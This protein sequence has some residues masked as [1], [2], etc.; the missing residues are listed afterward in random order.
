[1]QKIPSLF[2]RDYQDGRLVI[3]EIVPGSEW[4]TAGQAK[5]ATVKFDGTACLVK[6]GRLYKRYDRRLPKKLMQR[7]QAGLHT[8]SADEYPPAPEGWEPAQE[9]PD[10]K[11]GHWPGWLPVGDGPEDK[12]HREAW[13]NEHADRILLEGNPIFPDGP[14]LPDGTYEL[15]GPK[16]QSNPYGL[17]LHLLYRHGTSVLLDVPVDFY[18][19]RY[20]FERHP[21]LE[22][23]VWYHEDGRMVKLKRRDYG[24]PWPPQS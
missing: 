11:T 24:F 22:G 1:M 5:K 15:A 7:V 23:V 19:L 2:M 4:V 20:F 12:Y 17:D 10:S 14:V 13:A 18:G 21:Y 8:P 16:V 9:Q 3:N 6:D